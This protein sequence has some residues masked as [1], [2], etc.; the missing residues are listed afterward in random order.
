VATPTIETNNTG[1]SSSDKSDDEVEEGNPKKKAHVDSL[2]PLEA[3][4]LQRE[5][6]ILTPS[7]WSL[8]IQ[9]KWLNHYI[10][11]AWCLL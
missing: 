10:N 4:Q 9:G 11:C 2:D 1:S 6:C 7:R 3:H 5:K 8:L